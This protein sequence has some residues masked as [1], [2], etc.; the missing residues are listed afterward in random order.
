MKHSPS[1]INRINYKTIQLDSF[2]NTSFRYQFTFDLHSCTSPLAMHI[3]L[4]NMYSNERTHTAFVKLSP[5]IIISNQF[6]AN[7]SPNT[8][9]YK[10]NLK[11]H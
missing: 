3:F 6:P 4:L 7:G 11:H 1:Y 8:D 10:T 5:V 9:L 2:T